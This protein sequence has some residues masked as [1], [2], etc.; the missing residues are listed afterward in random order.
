MIPL[1]LAACSPSLP[2]PPE[3]DVSAF[4]T[5]LTGA[6]GVLTV[7][8]TY[9]TTLDGTV[10]LPEEPV[11]EGLTFSSTEAA[12]VERLGS[13]TVITQQWRFSGKKG[14]YEVR[15][16]S[17]TAGDRSAESTPVWVDLGVEAPNLA[18]LADITEP[19]AVWEIPVG[20]ILCV[21][22]GLVGAGGLA[23]LGLARVARPREKRV[24]VLPPDVRCL[25]AWELV[26]EDPTLTDDD[27][28]K[29]LSRLFRE[30]VEEVLGFPAVSW[31]TTEILAHLEGMQHLPK[32]NGAR[33][34]KLLRVTDLVKYAEV[35]PE[36]SFFDEMD[37]DL[38]AFIGSTRPAV[39]P[40]V[41]PAATGAEVTDG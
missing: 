6:G 8:T 3:L 21:V 28:A 23:V 41:E 37:A 39:W 40:P 20:P 5:D 27:R 35:S 12:R 9:P 11:V 4:A 18:Q 24:V 25:R 19:A 2:E 38:R 17:V 10:D 29:E 13:R 31:T 16:L 22:A 34:K 26:R 36:S 15:S 32:G 30:Y 7:V 14:S 33:A 1:L